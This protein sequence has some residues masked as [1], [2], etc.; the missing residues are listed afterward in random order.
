MKKTSSTAV[1]EKIATEPLSSKHKPLT[2]FQKFKYKFL[3]AEFLKKAFTYI[4]M[5]VLLLELV[6]V[7]L[8]PF[9]S[10]ITSSFMSGAD[11]VDRTVRLIPKAPTLENYKMAMERIGYQQSLV[12]T[13]LISALCGLLS[14][15]V[16]SFVGYGLAKFNFKGKN[17]LMF[18]ALLGFLIPP[19]TLLLPLFMRFRYF[20]VFNI[21]GLISGS[22]IN[23]MDTLWP[24]ILLTITGF[25]FRSGLYI[26]IMRQFYTGIPNELS[27]AAEIDGAGTFRTYYR[28]ML[29]LSMNMLV[30]IFLFSFAWQWTDTFYSGIF[31]SKFKVLSNTIFQVVFM[32][33]Q[34]VMYGTRLSSILLNSATL[35]AIVP[36]FLFYIVAQKRLVEGVEHSGI[37]G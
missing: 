22:K 3:T 28:I 20:D 14:I 29:P 5:Y 31:F 6:Y 7:I 36:L 4:L 11:I 2:R 9:I 26:F 30:T 18:F 27:E 17:I 21:V 25:G 1:I 32:P 15:F 33:E 12:N 16:S 37:V 19:Q 24:L 10:I 23:L 13:F 8:F 34:G 35:L